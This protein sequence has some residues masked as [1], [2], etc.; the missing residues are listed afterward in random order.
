MMRIKNNK[1]G[2]VIAARSY[3]DLDR[4]V[5]LDEF[6]ELVRTGAVVGIESGSEVDI[7]SDLGNYVEAFD[8]EGFIWFKKEDVELEE[9]EKYS[10]TPRKGLWGSP[11]ILYN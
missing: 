9:G 5:T 8:G 7:N 3:L 6:K 4:Q 1:E 2:Y 11:G 10:D